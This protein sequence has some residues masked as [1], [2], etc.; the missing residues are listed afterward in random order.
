MKKVKLTGEDH[1]Q[2]KSLD[3]ALLGL[4]I[5]LKVL[6]ATVLLEGS[7][8][9]VRSHRFILLF[10]WCILLF[11]TS[12]KQKKIKILQKKYIQLNSLGLTSPCPL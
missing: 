2:L 10:H 3:E 4:V 8:F 7:Q 6:L 9:S 11:P 5:E 1:G 12:I